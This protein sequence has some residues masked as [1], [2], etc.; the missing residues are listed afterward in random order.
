VTSV[1]LK[2][3]GIKGPESVDSADIEDG[4]FSIELPADSEY[5]YRLEFGDAF[6]PIFAE[7]G[8]HQLTADFKELYASSRYSNSPLTD[9]MRK[10]EML[11]LGFESKAQELQNQFETALFTGRKNSADSAKQ[12][13][14]FLQMDAKRKIKKLIDS[15]GP[16]PVSYLATS[17]LNQEEDYSY[18]DSLTSRFEKEK[19]GKAFTQKLQRFMELLRR[20]AIGK[21]APD[22]SLPNPAGKL[23]SVSTFKG[24][25]VLLDF[26]ASW[27]KPCRAENP[28]LSEVNRR[29]KDKG[30]KMFS[31]SLDADREAWMKAMVQDQMDWAHASDLKGWKSSVVALYGI[32]SIPASYLIDPE[33][34]IVAKNLRGRALLQ[35]LEEVFP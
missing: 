6:L 2:R 3:M 25:W 28:F 9:Q 14:E 15:I 31:V 8:E 16:G 13:F 26:W 32:N 33:G 19:P 11:R 21:T 10:T 24:S 23:I 35:K 27:C 34:K 17:M 29:Y 30:F 5:L 22:F 20:L 18:L 7:Q 4:K 12:A 1:K